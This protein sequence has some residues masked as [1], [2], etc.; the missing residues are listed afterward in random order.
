MVTEAELKEMNKR[1]MAH[2]RLI[3]YETR[4]GRIKAISHEKKEGYVT[5]KMGDNDN[6]NGVNKKDSIP[7]EAR[8]HEAVYPNLGEVD[9]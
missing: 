2:H 8:P 5:L 9:L 7:Q 1:K 3:F 4:D 6:P